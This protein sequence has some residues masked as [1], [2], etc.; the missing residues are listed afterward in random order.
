MWNI[1]ETVQY[2]DVVDITVKF[3]LLI[4]CCVWRRRL[5]WSDCSGSA[6]TIQTARVEDGGDLRTL[7]TD[8]D[9][10]CIVDIVIDFDSRATHSSLIVNA[11]ER[12]RDAPCHL[13]IKRATASLPMHCKVFL[14]R[15]LLLSQPSLFPDFRTGSEYAAPY[16]NAL[17]SFVL[18]VCNVSTWMLCAGN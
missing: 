15:T 14:C 11:T 16:K 10:A 17:L 9:H 2:R 7:I 4:H 3:H 12:T 13:K 1:S 18:Y 8:K 5:Y 6:P